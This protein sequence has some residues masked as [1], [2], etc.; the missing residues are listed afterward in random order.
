MRRKRIKSF[1]YLNLLLFLLFAPLLVVSFLAKNKNRLSEFHFSNTTESFFLNPIIPMVSLPVKTAAGMPMD[2][3]KLRGKW[4]L[5]YF[6]AERCD[7]NHCIPYLANMSTI[8]HALKQDHQRLIRMWITNAS[9][10]DALTKNT[11]VTLS[12]IENNTRLEPNQFYLVDPFGNL[13]LSYKNTTSPEQIL[14]DLQR[15][16]RISQIG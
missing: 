1:V 13:I 16:M 15:L 9:T 11:G 14:T 6:N 12:H 4:I 3:K 2:T 5:F 8:A 7:K 10:T